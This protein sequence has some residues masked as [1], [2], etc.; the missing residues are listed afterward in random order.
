MDRTDRRIL[1]ILQGNA[2]IS[3]KELGTRVG[4]SSPAVTERVRRLEEEGIIEGYR[5]IIKRGKIQKGM[6]AFVHMELPTS[7]WSRLETYCEESPYVLE[8]YHTIGVYG[9]MMK[10][11]LPGTEEFEDFLKELGKI[12]N[13]VSSVI[14]S[15]K[16]SEK[17]LAEEMEN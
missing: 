12:G 7:G 15:S 2:R 13:T 9:A 5:T 16:F 6:A 14:L 17:E 11:F 10:V 8:L 4:L 3:M 1:N